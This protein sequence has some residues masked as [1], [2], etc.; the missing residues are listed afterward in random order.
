[1]PLSGTNPQA[2]AQPPILPLFRPEAMAEQERMHGDV[3]RIRP[4]SLVFFAWLA[5]AAAAGMLI[6]LLLLL[7]G[8][9]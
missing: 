5:A 9:K 1:M 8:K 6:Y 3:L 2:E 7:V 4:L